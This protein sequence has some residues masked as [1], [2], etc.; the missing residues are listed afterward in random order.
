MKRG[1]LV[2][3]D[4]DL[5]AER[6]LQALGGDP[7]PCLRLLEL[8]RGG[9]VSWLLDSPSSSGAA[10]PALAPGLVEAATRGLGRRWRD[11][12]FRDRCRGKVAALVRSRMR[13]ALDRVLDDVA[14]NAAV[15]DVH[16]RCELSDDG[17]MFAARLAGRRVEVDVAVGLR[18]LTEIDARGQAI[19][20]GRLVLDADGATRTVVEWIPDGDGWTGRPTVEPDT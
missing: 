19:V 1:A 10:P 3:V 20:R 5:R 15:P 12:D 18:W 4:H 11:P 14:G 8:V 17:A 13:Q 6:A 7:P 2:L 9:L 16:L